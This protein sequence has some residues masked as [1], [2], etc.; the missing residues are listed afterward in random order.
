MEAI[1]EG[2]HDDSITKKIAAATH[3]T[4]APIPRKFGCI[5]TFIAARALLKASSRAALRARFEVGD[6]FS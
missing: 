3:R 1:R 5:S 2:G 6:G 4:E